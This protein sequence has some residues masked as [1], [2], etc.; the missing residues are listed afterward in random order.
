MRSLKFLRNFWFQFNRFNK[1]K[2]IKGTT[3][4][5]RGICFRFSSNGTLVVL[6]NDEYLGYNHLT[7]FL[8][9]KKIDDVAWYWEDM[10]L[11]L[12]DQSPLQ[13]LCVSDSG[14][15]VTT[16]MENGNMQAMF[17]ILNVCIYGTNRVIFNDWLFLA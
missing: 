2:Q 10:K 12:Q 6:H 16:G 17:V 4:Y 14:E 13:K 7:F 3:L 8:E 11:V 5:N 15:K 9:M 1:L